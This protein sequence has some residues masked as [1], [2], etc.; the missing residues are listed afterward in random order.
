MDDN[1]LEF[2]RMQ[3]TAGD[4]ARLARCFAS[5]DMPRLDALV[6][7][8]YG[9]PFSD[10][11]AVEF[12]VEPDTGDAGAIYATFPVPFSVGG[13]RVMGA[14]SLDTITGTAYRGQGLFKRLARVV[15]DRCEKEGIRLV[16][17]FPNGNSAHGFFQRLGWTEVAPV[18]FKVVAMRSAY[19][20][21]RLPV[22][23]RLTGLL[24][25]IRLRR[26][27]VPVAH[28]RNIRSLGAFGPEADALWETFC[29]QV[30]VAVARDA[31]YLRWRYSEK[32]SEDYSVLGYW[33]GERLV[34]LVV[35]TVKE[36]HG[37]RVGYVM[38]MLH[39]P[40]CDAEGSALLEASL[41]AM[42]ER[43]ADVCLAWNF[44][45][46]PNAPA[47]RQAGFRTLPEQLRPIELHFGVLPL[48]DSD[49]ALLTDPVQW[50]LSYSDSDTV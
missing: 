18:P 34:G 12:G 8:Q 47:Y 37:G 20:A 1:S 42:E 38:E 39:A 44:D 11:P 50:Y 45:H 28:Q 35:F 46:S 30:G 21:R 6:E 16:Y 22:I 14:Q 27:R 3:A 25:D 29:T 48:G 23:G 41:V 2:R 7:W 40:G 31:D 19:F 49:R 36:K 26:P 5:E 43:R 13:D 32:P 15:Y 24:P 17:G 4:Y 9:A 33:K 10:E